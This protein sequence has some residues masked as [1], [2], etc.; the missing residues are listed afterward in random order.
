M[1]NAT[2]T[3]D[4]EFDNDGTGTPGNVIVQFTVADPDDEEVI[5]ST[6]DEIG[7][8]IEA[9]IAGEFLGISPLYV[10]GGGVNLNNSLAG[11]HTVDA[12]TSG[13]TQ[14]GEVGVPGAVPIVYTPSASFSAETMAEVIAVAIN[15]TDLLVDVSAFAQDDRVQVYGAGGIDGIGIGYIPQIQDLAGNALKPNRLNGETRFTIF[16]DSAMDF[17]DA[18]ES[19]QTTDGQDGARH[20]VITGFSIGELLDTDVDGIPSAAA[21]GDDLDGDN[22]ED[23][24]VVSSPFTVAFD[25]VI[26]VTAFGIGDLDG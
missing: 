13:L 10:G 20:E 24:I 14:L 5:P 12:D 1:G 4:F 26:D 16:M 2:R 15:G 3:V 23:G 9:A 8:A 19:Y 7:E 25:G 17:G 21:D 18:P 11:V 6:T 22:D